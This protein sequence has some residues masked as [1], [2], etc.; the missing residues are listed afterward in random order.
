MRFTHWVFGMCAHVRG[1]KH[2]SRSKC[3]SD[4]NRWKK[5]KI[6]FDLQIFLAMR[7]PENLHEPFIFG[8]WNSVVSKVSKEA[9]ASLLK[10]FKESGGKETSFLK[11]R[12]I[13]L[14]SHPSI[15]PGKYRKCGPPIICLSTRSDAIFL[16]VVTKNCGSYCYP[17]RLATFEPVFLHKKIKKSVD[18][19]H[20]WNVKE[21]SDLRI[22]NDSLLPW[23]LLS[24]LSNP[25]LQSHRIPL[26]TSV[27]AALSPHGLL[28]PQD[29]FFSRFSSESTVLGR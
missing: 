25:G 14:K 3:T 5:K 28:S 27:H 16:N 21:I 29:C 2:S 1:F 17:K 26:S 11:S 4:W 18:L 23:H 13:R 8:S 24:I 22:L 15:E 7:T 9:H 20:P 12:E 19:W 6:Y 10:N